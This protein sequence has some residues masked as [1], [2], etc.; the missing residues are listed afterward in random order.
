MA[1]FPVRGSKQPQSTEQEFAALAAS[2]KRAASTAQ[3]FAAL[4]AH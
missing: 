3:L 1:K 2:S 4:K